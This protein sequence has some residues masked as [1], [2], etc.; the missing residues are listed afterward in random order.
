MCIWEIG[1]FFAARRTTQ[2]RVRF[3][4][5]VVHCL[6]LRIEN[7]SKAYSTLCLNIFVGISGVCC[8]NKWHGVRSN[9]LSKYRAFARTWRWSLGPGDIETCNRCGPPESYDGGS[10]A[11]AHH[12]HYFFS[13]QPQTLEIRRGLQDSPAYVLTL[14]LYHIHPQP[15]YNASRIQPH[16]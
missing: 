9:Y 14:S 16:H 5:D 12:A 2:V 6:Y 10:P 3:M 8:R 1:L 11:T 13:G 15:I 4:C 7:D